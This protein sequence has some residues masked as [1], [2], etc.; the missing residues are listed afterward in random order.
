MPMGWAVWGA[1]GGAELE[2][3]AQQQAQLV[4]GDVFAWWRQ[5]AAF[6]VRL[7]APAPVEGDRWEVG[8]GDVEE[9]ALGAAPAPS[10]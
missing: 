10:R 3:L 9:Q 4:L 6:A 1:A 8:I 5:R 7:E 2:E